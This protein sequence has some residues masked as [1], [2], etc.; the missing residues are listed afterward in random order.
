[1]TSGQG[2]LTVRRL[3]GSMLTRQALVEPVNPLLSERHPLLEL[4]SRNLPKSRL[5]KM[6]LSTAWRRIQRHAKAAGISA[7]IRALKHSLATLAIETAGVKAVQL[8]L[9]H[10]DANNTL[11]YADMLPA[12][13]SEGVRRAL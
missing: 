3:K 1:M 6:H 5:F 9:G 11:I 7:A 8:Q 12:E 2:D 4:A 13:A 10:N